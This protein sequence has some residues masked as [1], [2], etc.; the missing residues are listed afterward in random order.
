MGAAIRSD[1]AGPQKKELSGHSIHFDV[2]RECLG[3]SRW[4]FSWWFLSS[5]LL[6]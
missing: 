2:E 6:F 1:T 5:Y 3:L 4:R